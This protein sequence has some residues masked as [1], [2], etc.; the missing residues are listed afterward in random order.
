MALVRIDNLADLPLYYDRYKEGSYGVSAVPY[1]PYINER[2]LEGCEACFEELKTKLDA[3]GFTIKQVWSGGV[4]RDGSGTSYHHTNR[5]FDLDALVLDDDTMW[6]ADT[7]PERPF[8]YLA[9][10]SYLRRHFGTVLNYE[11]NSAHED[12]FHFDNGES[13]GYARRTRSHTLYVQN[14]LLRLFHLDIGSSGVDGIDGPDTQ[15]ALRKARKR[16]GIGGLS[17]KDNWMAYLDACGQEALLSE[18]SIVNA[19]ELVS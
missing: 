9:I 12:H 5:A 16:L 13:V 11:F 18:K 3:A 7:F 10:E 19:D 1:R 8:L 2:F 17:N 6:V 15:A 4:G 14:T